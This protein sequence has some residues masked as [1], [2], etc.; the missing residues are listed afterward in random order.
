MGKKGLKEV[1]N[2]DSWQKTFY[3]FDPAPLAFSDPTLGLPNP[4]PKMTTLYSLFHKFWTQ[5]TLWKICAETNRYASEI[6]PRSRCT[7]KKLR[8]GETWFALH[9]PELRPFLA[10]SLYMGIKIEPNGRCYWKK[11][12]EFLWCPAISS[13]MTHD[14]YEHIIWCLHVNNDSRATTD[15]SKVEFDK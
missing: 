14:R 10:I 1:F 2:E 6:N 15:R 12:C 5:K 3:R 9:P 8:G 13:I 4:S 7:S 11:S